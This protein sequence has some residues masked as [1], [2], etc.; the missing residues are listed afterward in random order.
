MTA[1]VHMLRGQCVLLTGASSG[2]GRALAL[3]L[4]RQGARLALA[5]RTRD[6]L[7]EVAGQCRALGAD[8]LVAPTDV[9]DPEACRAAV[10]ATVATFGG[11]D[12][13]VNNAGLTMWAH[14][15]PG[16]RLGDIAGQHRRLPLDPR[17]T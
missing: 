11:L 5:A 13:L 7:E 2:I 9:T 16:R 17:F 1:H 8:A 14:P 3:R 15:L 4:A 6:A 10:E 12:A